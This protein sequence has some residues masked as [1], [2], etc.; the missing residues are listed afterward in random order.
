VAW[1]EGRGA[2]GLKKGVCAKEGGPDEKG[3]EEGSS[4]GRGKGGGSGG[5][6]RGEGG[7]GGGGKGKGGGEG[8]G[9]R[10]GDR[11]KLSSKGLDPGLWRGDNETVDC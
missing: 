7:R 1:G 6:E 4:R 10:G 11:T 5:G 8:E 3:G 9:G 2:R